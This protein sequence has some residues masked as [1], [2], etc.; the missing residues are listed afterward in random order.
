MTRQEELVGIYGN[1]NDGRRINV[2]HLY[3]NRD[4]IFNNNPLVDYQAILSNVLYNTYYDSVNLREKLDVIIN[5]S[6]DNGANPNS[7]YVVYRFVKNNIDLLLDH[8]IRPLTLLNF[9]QSLENF[10]FG[11][12]DKDVIST[13]DSLLKKALDR[14]V[15]LKIYKF[16]IEFLYYHSDTLLNHEKNHMTL[17]D[18]LSSIVFT[19]QHNRDEFVV[20]LLEKKAKLIELY[21]ELASKSNQVDFSDVDRIEDITVEKLVSNSVLDKNSLIE[22]ALRANGLVY[23]EKPSHILEAVSMQKKLLEQLITD[24][25]NINSMSLGKLGLESNNVQILEFLIQKGLNPYALN[26]R[27]FYYSDGVDVVNLLKK[28]NASVNVLTFMQESILNLAEDEVLKLMLDNIDYSSDEILY[29]DKIFN[30]I[31]SYGETFKEFVSDSIPCTDNLEWDGETLLH[32]IVQSNRAS[33]VEYFLENHK[34]NVNALDKSGKTP[35]FSAKSEGVVDIL[36]RYNADFNIRDNDGR[37]WVY[38]SPSNL[39]DYVINKNYI[40]SE[41]IGNLLSYQISKGNYE[42][43][44][45]LHQYAP[46]L[47][48]DLTDIF[49]DAVMNG[50]DRSIEQNKHQALIR[51]INNAGIDIPDK[52]NYLI[53][54]VS[55]NHKSQE[56]DFINGLIHK[57]ADYYIALSESVVIQKD[58]MVYNDFFHDCK[59]ITNAL[60]TLDNDFAL[61]ILGVNGIAMPPAKF[62]VVLYRGVRVEAE[63]DMIESFFQFGHRAFSNVYNQKFLGFYVNKEWNVNQGN[64]EYGGTYLSLSYD[65][66]SIYSGNKPNGGLLFQILAQEKTNLVCGKYKSHYEVIKGT[67]EPKDI[68]AVYHITRYDNC[69]KINDVYVNPYLD[70][71]EP[72]F[73]KDTCL[74]EYNSYE[75]NGLMEGQYVNF[76][77]DQDQYINKY[78][79]Y[80]DFI[81]RYPEEGVAV[82]ESVFIKECYNNGYVSYDSLYIYDGCNIMIECCV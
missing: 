31:A 12:A 58:G 61:Q 20:Q 6:M 47:K 67:V 43:I 81:S 18:F 55:D 44:L 23:G 50:L 41:D 80:N 78:L 60:N 75:K 70:Q 38:E 63:Q 15:D 76:C 52:F 49:I 48:L 36:I 11:T 27:N 35:L 34:C 72:K 1:L 46:N 82:D 71:A 22:L 65:M 30:H 79:D 66:A 29:A 40:A 14:G 26:L 16:S 33:I 68:I 24:D 64:F 74:S 32:I 54:S 21:Y 59:V 13:R 28:Y 10:G 53:Y 77:K 2:D 25:V 37:T 17:S 51:L 9:L 19:R 7:C 8:P 45:K 56:F 57:L 73:K 69:T 62:D 3:E 39:I 5:L 42:K 4:L